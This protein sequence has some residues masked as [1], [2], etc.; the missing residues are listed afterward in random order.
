M[1]TDDGVKGEGLAKAELTPGAQAVVLSEPSCMEAQALVM[2]WRYAV[3]MRDHLKCPKAVRT[4]P[5][6]IDT[7]N[8]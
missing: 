6:V 4:T 2:A 8:P 7:R 1:V 5:T 3:C